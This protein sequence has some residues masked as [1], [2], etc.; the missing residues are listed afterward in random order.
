MSSLLPEIVQARK[1]HTKIPQKNSFYG[2][3][4]SIS[5]PP[6]RN[7][8]QAP[9]IESKASKKSVTTTTDNVSTECSTPKYKIIRSRSVENGIEAAANKYMNLLGED[10]L[11]L[12]FRK[13]NQ[14]YSPSPLQEHEITKRMRAKMVDWMVEVFTIFDFMPDSYFLAVYIF[15]KYLQRTNRMLGNDNV[16]LI[17]T[18]AMFLSTK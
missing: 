7:K 14:S 8:S 17:G 12:C 13:E 11:S 1:K 3:K 15:D 10:Y 2:A 6:K 4:V 18:V 9:R 5:K 16:H